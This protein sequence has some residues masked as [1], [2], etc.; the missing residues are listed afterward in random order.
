MRLDK[1][2]TKPK[3]HTTT[4]REK[5]DKVMR[6]KGEPTEEMRTAG[7]KHI[8]IK[9][10][11]RRISR[12]RNR[13]GG[14]T[15]LSELSSSNK[16]GRGSRTIRFPWFPFIERGTEQRERER[17]TATIYVYKDHV[18]M[19]SLP[20]LECY[21]PNCFKIAEHL[22]VFHQIYIHICIRIIH[23]QIYVYKIEIQ[24]S[25]CLYLFAL[26]KYEKYLVL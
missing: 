8:K 5:E 20:T 19:Y 16:R 12:K 4:Y 22:S 23:I 2:K 3:I 18:T 15:G 25:C 6:R 26:I 13:G 1:R 24:E 9:K 21:R 14:E 17:T 7:K 11:W 10:W